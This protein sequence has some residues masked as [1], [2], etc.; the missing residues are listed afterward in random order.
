MNKLLWRL[1]IFT[2]GIDV[3]GAGSRT[4]SQ[5]YN[6]DVRGRRG[7]ITLP[8]TQLVVRNGVLYVLWVPEYTVSNSCQCSS[9]AVCKVAVSSVCFNHGTENVRGV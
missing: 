7:I 1:P 5:T 6:E 8:C 9:A 2:G 3:T 4:S